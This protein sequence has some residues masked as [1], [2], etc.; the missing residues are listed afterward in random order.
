MRTPAKLAGPLHIAG[1]AH[2]QFEWVAL[3]GGRFHIPPTPPA[4]P[5]CSLPASSAAPAPPVQHPRQSCCYL[6]ASAPSHLRARHRARAMPA[7]LPSQTC[8]VSCQ[9]SSGRSVLQR[10]NKIT[11]IP[12][13]V[14]YQKQTGANPICAKLLKPSCPESFRFARCRGWARLLRRVRKKPVY[15]L[16]LPSASV[17]EGW[18]SSGNLQLSRI[19][20]INKL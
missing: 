20:I 10:R 2:S 16:G 12:S 14:V 15:S 9:P 6:A 17:P 4:A 13:G 8:T 18:A 19:K 3:K 7:R 11:S 5:S 1:T